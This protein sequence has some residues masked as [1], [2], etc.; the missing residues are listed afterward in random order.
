[1]ENIN[2]NE[3]KIFMSRVSFERKNDLKGQFRIVAKDEI[4]DLFI[5]EKEISLTYKRHVKLD[6]EALFDITVEF[7]YSAQFDAKS[8]E[9]L[10]ASNFKISEDTIIKIIE[11][12]TIPQNASLVISNLT[13]INGGNPLITPPSFCK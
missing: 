11:G 4:K 9:S 3:Q 12:A 5:N 13:F 1:M 10:K 7:N 6:P 2:L 8:S